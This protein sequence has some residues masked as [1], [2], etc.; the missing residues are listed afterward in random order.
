M[1]EP[2][3]AYSKQSE[4]PVHPVC[5][6]SFIQLSGFPIGQMQLVND[7]NFIP[8]A[9]KSVV[10]PARS[11]MPSKECMLIAEAQHVGST[12]KRGSRFSSSSL[13][14]LA[15]GTP[16]MQMNGLRADPISARQDPS[17][18][19]QNTHTDAPRTTWELLDVTHASGVISSPGKFD[20]VILKSTALETGDKARIALSNV[21]AALSEQGKLIFLQ[22]EAGVGTFEHTQQLLEEVGYFHSKDLSPSL[23]DGSI[24]AEVPGESVSLD[25]IYLLPIHGDQQW[26]MLQVIIQKECNILWVTKGG[27]IAVTDPERAAAPGLLRTIRSEEL[28][29]RLIAL[30]V[31][32][33]TGPQAKTGARKDTDQALDEAKFEPTRGR[34]PQVEDLS[35]KKTPVCLG[36]ERIGTI[37]SL[38][39][40]ELSSS[41]LPVQEDFI[42]V[43]VFAAGI[44]FKDL[45]VTL[46]TVSSADTSM[47]GSEAARIV[48][49]V[50][51]GVEK[52]SL[53]QRVALMFPGSF[54]NRI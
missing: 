24:L 2:P 5:I 28:G 41:P 14:D 46:G 38:Q 13:C 22:P 37:G 21:P 6:D 48:T 9:I 11:R 50:E 30:D 17:E 36:V 52:S 27:Q 1:E 25:K 12:R 8:A 45:A 29:L 23:G 10:I 51:S 40:A 20:L 39:Y 26:D 33:S 35:E 19:I 43:E 4:Y 32:E 15:D 47:L 54:A 18:H 34:E 3:S 44:N 53:G 42:E 7:T 49:R 16:V 31:Q